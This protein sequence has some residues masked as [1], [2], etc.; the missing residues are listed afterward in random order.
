MIEKDQLRNISDD[1]TEHNAQSRLD[2]TKP[3]MGITGVTQ[4][5][6]NDI[7]VKSKSVTDH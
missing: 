5:N 2:F 6:L 3:D 1:E 7:P 4:T